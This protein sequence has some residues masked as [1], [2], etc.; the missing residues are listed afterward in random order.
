M[1]SQ[2]ERNKSNQECLVDPLSMFVGDS[3]KEDTPTK[4]SSKST[5]LNEILDFENSTTSLLS[6]KQKVVSKPLDLS[7]AKPSKISQSLSE[8]TLNAEKMQNIDVLSHSISSNQLSISNKTQ[9]SQ[10]IAT[11]KLAV[12]DDNVS[13]Q[14]P[15]LSGEKVI[16]S[17]NDCQINHLKGNIISGICYITTY[18]IYFCPPAFQLESLYNVYPN[19]HSLLNIPLCCIDRIEKERKSS[20]DNRSSLN[21]TTIVIN[22]K[23]VRVVKLFIKFTP[24]CNEH[25]IDRILGKMLTFTFP[26]NILYA[27]A[28]SHQLPSSTP[29]LETNDITADFFRQNILDNSDSCPWRMSLANKDFRLCD[30]YSEILFVPKK[31]TDEELFAVAS[32]RSGNRLPVL[33]WGDKNN[34]ATLWRSS[35][36]KAGMQNKSNPQDEKYLD[37]IAKSVMYRR[38]PERGLSE[39]ILHIVD[40]RPKTSAL[41]NRAAGA[42]YETNTN[43]PNTRIEFYNIGN[44]HV[45]RD[46]LKSLISLVLTNNQHT[47]HD[48][49]FSKHVEETQWL[50]HLRLVLKASWESANYIMK[51]MPVLIHCSHGWDR[52]AQTCSL[53]LLFLD[54][55]YRTFDGFKALIE[56][57]W[58]SYG[59]QFCLRAGHM[60]DK[61]NRQDDQMSP[62]FLQ[63]VDC[64][65]QL[66]RQ[67]PYL[68]EFNS[69]YLLTIADHIYS[70]RFGTFLFNSDLDRKNMS[71]RSKCMDIWS[72]LHYNRSVLTNPL[73]MSSESGIAASASAWLP[74]LSQ[75]LR[76]VTLWCDYYFRFTSIPSL[77]CPP[78]MIH[79][80][81]SQD[82]V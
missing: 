60:Q 31:I 39:P 21:G 49:N 13:S 32:F 59:H 62:I 2:V 27:F 75:V 73:Y 64:V 40:C 30:S 43:Y 54:P 42:G 36:P 57:E 17:M 80:N 51:G 28:F 22:C 63:F 11:N 74:P 37:L 3:A 58:C 9:I 71:T 23:D 8:G 5:I 66:S 65:W 46:S 55:Y 12:Y 16:S 6:P 70:G 76:N 53:T 81:L 1:F 29:R 48:S 15:Q 77:I 72:Y 61:N 20:K 82:G 10:E 50:T 26:N 34:G 33:C 18:R 69:R 47:N 44:I 52:T 4:A 35:Q 14:L 45:M 78:V 67:Y 68:F 24:T 56:R 7:D 79:S 19:I 41:A 25:E 38:N